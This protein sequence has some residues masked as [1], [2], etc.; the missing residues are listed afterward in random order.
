[1]DIKGIICAMHDIIVHNNIKNSDELN[2]TFLPFNMINKIYKLFAVDNRM[3]TFSTL[4]FNECKEKIIYRGNP[5]NRLQNWLIDFQ[6]KEFVNHLKKA[7]D[8]NK[9]GFRLRYGHGYYFTNNIDYVKLHL[10]K[11]HHN[12]VFN[13]DEEKYIIRAKLKSSANII[14]IN[15]LYKELDCF[16][17]N[18]EFAKN[19]QIK[20]SN[21]YEYK[22]LII[23]H[24]LRHQHHQ[25]LASLFLGYDGII[26][27]RTSSSKLD[28]PIYHHEYV[29]TNRDVL[30]LES[31]NIID[32]IN[33]TQK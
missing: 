14:N 26:V 2:S 7:R 15:D 33:L 8:V 23:A 16:I 6:E 3:A 1:M 5:K 20:P 19:I 13:N 29:I 18:I 28:Y 12:C 9:F 30:L 22:K 10:T 24:L 21:T 17:P 25:T 11:S 31:R 27:K 4:E 32:P